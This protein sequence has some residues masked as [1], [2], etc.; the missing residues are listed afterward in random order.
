MHRIRSH[1]KSNLFLM[2]MILCLLFLSLTC[3]VCIRLFAAA[4]ENRRQ[5]R[6]LNHI[7]E[8]STTVAELLKAWDTN[9][10]QDYVRLLE[11]RGDPLV[12]NILSPG[13]NDLP[14]E[15]LYAEDTPCLGSILLSF[16]RSWQPC[17]AEE[18]VEKTVIRLYRGNLE[19]AA[20]LIF[21][22]D[23][24]STEEEDTLFEFTVRY[25]VFSAEQEA[26]R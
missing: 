5:A 25:P 20:S 26:A 9:N 21:L 11:G 13:E 4:Y 6:N 23:N 10:I 3:S 15:T 12:L 2:E 18:A 24:R 7:Q 22:Q 16:D 8:Y 17:P 1:S 14:S 19:K